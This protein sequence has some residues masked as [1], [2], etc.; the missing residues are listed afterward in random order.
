[1]TITWYAVRASGILAFV[2]LTLSVALGLAVSGKAR[3]ALWP[4]FAIED[5]HGFAGVLCGIFIVLHGFA[6]LV[7]SYVPF[8]LS[9]LLIPGTSSYRPLAVALGV[10][11]A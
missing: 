11:A 1:M 5:V 6:L 7:D 8:S 2:L 9:Q 10:L 3:S 4:R